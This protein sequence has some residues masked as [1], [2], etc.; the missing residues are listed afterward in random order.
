MYKLASDF[1]IFKFKK[2]ITHIPMNILKKK[3]KK[4]KL[5]VCIMLYRLINTE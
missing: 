1:R 3:F 2:Y 4:R 5:D